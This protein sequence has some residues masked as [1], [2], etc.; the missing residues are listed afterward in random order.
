MQAHARVQAEAVGVGAEFTWTMR[1]AQ[2]PLAHECEHLAPRPWPGC[3][4]PGAGGCLQRR[5]HFIR[6]EAVAARQIR[7]AVFLDQVAQ[8]CEQLQ[9]APD[10]FVKH[11]L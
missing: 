2:C 6:I 9:D 1:L 5:H 11:G 8:A 10:E 3:D 4:A 7:D